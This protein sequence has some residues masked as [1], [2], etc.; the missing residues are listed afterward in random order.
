MSDN[1]AHSEPKGDSKYSATVMPSQEGKQASNYGLPGIQ[2]PTD[3][4]VLESVFT[5]V[6]NVDPKSLNE[7]KD[8]KETK[9]D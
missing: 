2:I 1:N 4:T 9:K 7:D 6:R 3:K 8:A 5:Q